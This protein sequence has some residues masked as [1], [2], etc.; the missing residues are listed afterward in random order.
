MTE[1]VFER[2]LVE[3]K[4]YVLTKCSTL[5][6]FEMLFEKQYVRWKYSVRHIY[7]DFSQKWIS[8]PLKALESYNVLYWKSY[9][10]DTTDGGQMFLYALKGPLY[11][12]DHNEIVSCS[13]CFRKV[14]SDRSFQMKAKSKERQHRFDENNNTMLFSGLGGNFSFQ[15]SFWTTQTFSE[16]L[17]PKIQPEGRE[18]HVCLMETYVMGWGAAGPGSVMLNFLS[19]WYRITGRIK[20]LSRGECVKTLLWVK[21]DYSCKWMLSVNSRVILQCLGIF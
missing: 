9:F 4:D 1:Q 10:L 5:V 3:P 6:A 8:C 20:A 19:V 16:A 12:A 15:S 21:Y 11:V 13:E 7:G 17:Y 18:V 14:A 2:G